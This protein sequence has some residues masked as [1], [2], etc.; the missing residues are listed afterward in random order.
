M[1]NDLTIANNYLIN[2]RDLDIKLIKGL[3]KQGQHVN[4]RNSPNEER[5]DTVTF[6]I[7][8]QAGRKHWSR[9]INGKTEGGGKSKFHYG[10]SWKGYWWKVPQDNLHKASEIYITEGIFDAIALRMH[11]FCAV[12]IMSAHV[13]PTYALQELGKKCDEQGTTRPTLIW[14]LD[15]DN[16][17]KNATKKHLKTL[18]ENEHTLGKW[19]SKCA[20]PPKQYG[21]SLDWNDLHKLGREDAK[22]RLNN[23]LMERLLLKGSLLIVDN[24]SDKAVILGKHFESGN[25]FPIEHKKCLYWCTRKFKKDE[26]I[27]QIEMV[28]DFIPQFLTF[29]QKN[30]QGGSYGIKINYPDGTSKTA[31][32]SPTE[33]NNADLFSVKITSISP[34]GVWFG[35]TAQLKEYRKRNSDNIQCISEFDSLGYIEEV[36]AYVFPEVAIYND[37]IIECDSN[38]DAFKIGAH[39][40]K[41]TAQNPKLK[42]HADNENPDCDNWMAQNWPLHYHRAFGQDGIVSLAYWMGSL[43]A[44]QIRAKQESFPFLE[45]AGEPGSGKTTM[46]KFLWKLIGFDNTEGIDFRKYTQVALG[47]HIS[48]SVN[49]PIVCIESDHNIKGKAYDYDAHKDFYNGYGERGRGFK[50]HTNN[51][52]TLKFKGSLV[53]AQN[54]RINASEAFMQRLI[55]ISSTKKHHNDITRK[56]AQLLEDASTKDVQHFLFECITSKEDIL[57]DFFTKQR[58]YEEELRLNPKIKNSRVIK[59]Y[60]QIMALIDCLNWVLFDVDTIDNSF[61]V[62]EVIKNALLY[63]T[64]LAENHETILNTDNVIAE[65]FWELY[66]YLTEIYEVNHGGGMRAHPILNHYGSH[67]DEIAIN[68]HEFLSYAAEARMYNLPTYQVLKNALINGKTYEFVCDNHKISRSVINGKRPR[69]MIFKKPKNNDLQ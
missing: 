69:C 35:T 26:E 4:Y 57:N 62:K 30:G 42:L 50:D 60:A 20:L 67:A 24:I 6:W 1:T 9:L 8:T 56:N 68:L 28:A 64:E 10:E 21:K 41:T 52:N 23:D 59:N 37:K 3:Y 61:V 36:D 25:S 13:F 38:N 48:Q 53:F 46:L 31:D 47:R 7:D 45:I 33:L 18:T 34:K 58:Q 40:V 43:F 17:G 5:I 2:E 65:E 14:A 55:H 11:G 54:N 32:F 39:Y 63:T 49:L 16:A 44:E 22:Y 66:Y 19:R 51:V 27:F 12:A 29:S 15:S